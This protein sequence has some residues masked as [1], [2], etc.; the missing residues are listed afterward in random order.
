ML[1]KQQGSGPQP[2]PASFS[3]PINLIHEELYKRD[4][5]IK[6]ITTDLNNQIDVLIRRQDAL[7]KLIQNIIKTTQIKE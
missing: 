6:E 5:L 2:Q 1:R 4:Q 7:Y 3:N